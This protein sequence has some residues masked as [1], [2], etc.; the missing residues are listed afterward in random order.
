MREWVEHVMRM[1]TEKLV[2]ISRDN[3]PGR[4]RSLGYPKRR[5]SGLIPG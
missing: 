3:I 1:V 4:R 5:W 2:K